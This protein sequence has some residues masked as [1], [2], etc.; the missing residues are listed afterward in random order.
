MHIFRFGYA[1]VIA[2]SLLACDSGNSG[3]QDS[4]EEKQTSAAIAVS[5]TAS[6]NEAAGT[7]NVVLHLAAGNQATITYTTS[8]GSAGESDFVAASGTIQLDTTKPETTIPIEI[9]DDFL[10]E[11]AEAFILHWSVDDVS[12]SIPAS[13][14][15]T[16]TDDDILAPLSGTGSW[17]AIDLFHPVG[18]C[19]QCHK[20]SNIG[21]IPAAMRTGDTIPAPA[22]ADISPAADWRHSLM[23]HSLNDP[24]YTAKVKAEAS[25]NPH[26]ASFIEDKCLGCHAP[27]AHVLAQETGR[28]VT[29][30]DDPTC[31]KPEG[32]LSMSNA[33]QD[34]MSREGISCTL[35][36]RID[37]RVI[38]EDRHSG[39]YPL[40]SSA[41]IPLLFGPFTAPPTQ[42]MLNQLGK[43]PAY[44]D[45]MLRSEHCASCHDLFTPVL[46]AVTRLPTGDYFPEQTPYREWRNSDYARGQVSA[47]ECQECHMPAE[48]GLTTPIAVR[49]NGTVNTGWPER[50]PYA[51]HTFVGGNTHMLRVLRDYRSALGI[52]GTTTTTGFD[53]KISE[54]RSLL[55]TAAN[56]TIDDTHIDEGVLTARV[57]VTNRTGHK[58][59]TGYPSRRLWIA[60]TVTD[61]NGDTVFESGIADSNGL[62]PVDATLTNAACSATLAPAESCIVPHHDIITDP[63]QVQIYEAVL[64]TTQGML[65]HTLLL[66]KAYLKDNRLPPSGFSQND[67]RY[68]DATAVIGVTGDPDFNIAGSGRDT[69]RYTVPLNNGSGPWVVEARLYLQSIRPSF[70]TS[71]KADTNSGR[72]FRIMMAI[73]PPIPELLTSVRRPV[74]AE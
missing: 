36:H 37:S 54:T 45:H 59:P 52:T 2:A 60:F 21:A 53:Q 71:T 31:T 46:D 35:C 51:R 24:W 28:L 73:T 40:D 33:L 69:V 4:T 50:S 38:A 56:L 16:I 15:I 30:E 7:L 63:A 55:A 39:D 70:I 66:A 18:D 14:T 19:T 42:P 44:S 47:T 41:P 64:G 10:P 72:N 1:V 5:P 23:A 34:S 26:L 27:M 74:A 22:G 17:S 65:T 49:G 68:D 20:A 6:V 62:L 48:P 25:E 12:T 67:V 57:T 13:T 9:N 32:C 61:N 11:A 29:A 58:L 3:R 8:T 43:Q